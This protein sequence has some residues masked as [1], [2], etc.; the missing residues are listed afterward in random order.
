MEI[1]PIAYIRTD[2][3]EKFGIPRQGKCS[4]LRGRIEFLPEYQ[5]IDAFYALD[6]FSHIW[7]LFDFS[8]AHR[9]KWSPTV[10][11]PRLGG[12]KR[13]G[14]FASRSPFRPNNIGLSC[15]RLDAIKKEKNKGIVL[16]VSGV[17]MLDMT[18]VYDIKPYLPFSDRIDD[19]RGGYSDEFSNYRIKVDFPKNLLDIVDADKRDAL[20]ECI[21]Q[22]P[23][24]T[25]HNDGRVY[26]MGFSCYDIHFYVKDCCAYII[27]V[28]N[29][30][31]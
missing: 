18:P 23:R 6:G 29:K 22:D 16:E 24:P 5:N 25:Y 13:V 2:F 14:V 11:P 17:D 10:R 7:V 12:N 21:S 4:L 1:L 27:R 3:K 31:L 8:E 28:E 9:E 19:A 26:K 20:I 15:V 30:E